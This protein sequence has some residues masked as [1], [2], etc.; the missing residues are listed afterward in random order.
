[1]TTNTDPF[2][3]AEMREAMRDG[4]LSDPL[5]YLEGLV[6]GADVREGNA[7]AVAVQDIDEFLDPGEPPTREEW[8]TL[9]DFVKFECTY[10][11]VTREQSM[12]AAKTLA[13]YLHPKR[14]TVE[15]TNASGGDDLEAAPLTEEEITLFREKFNAEF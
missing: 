3:I 6:R 5:L 9:V 11:S 8:D 2:T 7:V 4:H 14:K 13:E 10:G 1:M 12:S 15:H